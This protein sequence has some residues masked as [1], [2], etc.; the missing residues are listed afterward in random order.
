MLQA[1]V[2]TH[3]L[4]LLP[5]DGLWQQDSS[6]Y[7]STIYHAST[8]LV[9]AALSSSCILQPSWQPGLCTTVAAAWP[10]PSY[11]CIATLALA[12]AVPT[13]SLAL[14]AHL[15]PPAPL[16]MSAAVSNCLFC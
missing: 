10:T 11:I 8:H 15:R 14:G 5:P 12:W 4:P 9:G 2:R 13:A 1:A 6:V 3:L 16:H 7:H